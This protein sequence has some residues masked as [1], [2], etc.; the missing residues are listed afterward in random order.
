MTNIAIDSRRNGI[1]YSLKNDVAVLP[2]TPNIE[3]IANPTEL[4]LHVPAAVPINEPVK[5]EPADF[6]P[7]LSARVL[8][9]AMLRTNPVSDETSTISVQIPKSHNLEHTM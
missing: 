3:N 8:Y 7:S 2:A 6:F 4:Q 5:P 9:I 1:S